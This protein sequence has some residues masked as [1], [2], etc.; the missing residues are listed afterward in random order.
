MKSAS[1]PPRLAE[2]LLRWYSQ[3]DSTYGR[4]A[5]IDDLQGDIE[6]LFH[7]D[8]KRFSI[9]KANFNYW[10]RVVSLI[11]SYAMTK[12]KKNAAYHHFSHNQF[13]P[14]MFKNY[15]KTAVRSLAKNKFLA[16]VNV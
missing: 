2:N 4:Q 1:K 7:E 11:F 15:F 10:R 9:G 8:V 13:T 6:E 14:D 5:H 12:R 16:T 3:R